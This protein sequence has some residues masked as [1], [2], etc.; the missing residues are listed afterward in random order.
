M[1]KQ[2][3]TFKKVPDDLRG[4]AWEPPVH[5]HNPASEAAKIS[6]P[7]GLEGKV[8]SNKRHQNHYIRMKEE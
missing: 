8:L 1:C 7:N 5:A 4:P 6:P 3:L 2:R